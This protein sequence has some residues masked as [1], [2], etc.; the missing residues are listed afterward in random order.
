MADLLTLAWACAWPPLFGAAW[1]SPFRSRPDLSRFYE[2]WA[3]GALAG[4][5][6][7]GAARDLVPLAISVLHLT[8]AAFLWWLSRR[9]RDRAPRSYGAKSGALLAALVRK[10][11]EAGKPRPVLRPAPGGAR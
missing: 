4:V 6:S 1:S 5:L 3:A 7:F 10:A 11:R 8:L 9:R 2:A